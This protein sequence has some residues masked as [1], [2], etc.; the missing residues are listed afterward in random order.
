MLISKM[1][2]STVNSGPLEEARTSRKDRR[3][4]DFR[5]P[6]FISNKVLSTVH[7]GPPI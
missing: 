2:L 4:K 1:V 5:E 7:F 6:K 3:A